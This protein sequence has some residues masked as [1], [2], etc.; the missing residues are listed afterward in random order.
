MWRL[1]SLNILWFILIQRA[2][3]SYFGSQGMEMES[4][5]K[6]GIAGTAWVQELWQKKAGVQL[7]WE[8]LQSNVELWM[9]TQRLSAVRNQIDTLSLRYQREVIGISCKRMQT[10]WLHPVRRPPCTRGSSQARTTGLVLSI[11]F[12]FSCYWLL[13]RWTSFWLLSLLLQPCQAAVMQIS[14]WVVAVQTVI[15]TI[16]KIRSK[17]SAILALQRDLK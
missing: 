6:T 14:C 16:L 15:K 2:T 5:S 3:C 1:Q 13:R 12:S 11:C 17:N 4:G 8:G 10:E 7:E 9:V